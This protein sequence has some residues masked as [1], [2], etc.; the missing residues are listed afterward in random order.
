MKKIMLTD[1]IEAMVTAG[2]VGACVTILGGHS[3]HGPHGWALVIGDRVNA[4][5]LECRIQAS[6]NYAVVTVNGRG[7]HEV[8]CECVREVAS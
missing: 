3:E 5:D 4:R 7:M 8:L 2:P 1:N 6:S